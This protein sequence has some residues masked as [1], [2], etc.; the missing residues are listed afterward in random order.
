MGAGS[1]N[2]WKDGREVFD[3]VNLIYTYPGGVHLIYDSL[4]SNKKYGY[5]EQIQG[6]K[7][8]IEPEKGVIFSETPPPAPGIVQLVN[9]IEHKLFEAMPI[10]GPSWVPDNPS[11]DKGKYL[12]ERILRS[13]GSDMEQEAFVATVREGK[14]IPGHLEQ[15]Y[16]AT[17]ASILGHQAMVE[18]RIIEFP[19]ELVL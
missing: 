3:N 11:E 12:V 8:T 19:K 15:G 17:I 10:G 5:E 16:Y 1:I 9:S 2:Y 13:D 14:P 18:K 6:D 7:G 4:V